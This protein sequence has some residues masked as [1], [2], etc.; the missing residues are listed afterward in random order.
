MIIP[1]PLFPSW[2]QP[3]LR[4]LPFSALMDLPARVYTGD[5]PTGQVG[6]VLLHQAA[7]AIGLFLG[8]RWL[9]RRATRRLV[10]QGG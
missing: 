5:I 8:G 7:W 2:L 9:L 3:L 1:L 6:G 10:V 4:W